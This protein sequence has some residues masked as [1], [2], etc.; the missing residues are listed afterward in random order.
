MALFLRD[1]R[2]PKRMAVVWRPGVR[3][4][5]RQVA[6]AVAALAVL[7]EDRSGVAVGQPFLLGRRPFP[8]EPPPASAT[9]TPGDVAV[10][11][12]R[13]STAAEHTPAAARTGSPACSTRPFRTTSPASS[14]EKTSYRPSQAISAN[15]PS[16]ARCVTSGSANTIRAA[17]GGCRPIHGR[18]N[19]C[20][21]L[22][23]SASPKARETASSPITLCE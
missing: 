2:E 16:T 23:S 1:A 22:L 18:T 4:Q 10:L 17:L 5:T 14:L 20:T 21:G 12:P 9:A 11:D 15:S 6:R 8:Q 7:G 19:S 13:S 3:W